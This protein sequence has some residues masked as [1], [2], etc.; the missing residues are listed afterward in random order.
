MR[1]IPLWCAGV[2]LLGCAH[3]AQQPKPNI[4]P[5]RLPSGP[6]PPALPESAAT[7]GPRPVASPD[8]A[9]V[10]GW[11]PLSATRAD[12]FVK[13]HPEWDGRGVLIGILDSGIDAGVPGLQRTPT[14][15]PKILD[16]RDF[17][18][19]GRVPLEKL[20]PVGDSVRIAGTVLAGMSRVRALNTAGPWYGGV[21]V[22]RPLGK[23]PASDINGDGDDA[24]SL[25][26]LVTQA[27]DGWVLLADTDG[28]GSLTGERPIRDYLHGRDTFGWA[29]PQSPSPITIAVN[30]EAKDGVP[31]LDLFFDNGG[32]GTH[33][34]GIAAANDMY[35]LGHFN[36]VAPGAQLLG[37]KISNNAH[38]G[39]TVNGSMVRALDYAI[40]FA[41]AR[42]MPLVLNM[43][44]G[45]G[46]EFEG[47]ARIDLILDSVLAANP[48]VA[49]AISAGNDG[50][51]LSTVGFPGSA[52]RA[53][54]VGATFPL[55]FLA[56]APNDG[57]PDPVAYFSSRGGEI[58]KPDV[59]TPG[60]AYSTVPRWSIGEERKGGTS[61]ASPHAAGILALLASAARAEHLTPPS[62]RELKQAV[63]VTAHPI[64]GA[65]YLDE[66]AGTPDVPAAWQWLTEGHTVPEVG[67]RLEGGQGVS[68]AF[69]R[70]GF[71][72]PGDT[73]Q[74]FIL[75]RPAGSPPLAVT[76]RSDSPWLSTPATAQLVAGSNALEVAYRRQRMSRPGVY[77][78]IVSGWGPDS[79]A[80]PLFR[81]VNTVVVP[82]R[83][84]TTVGPVQLAAGQS[85]RI[86]FAVDSARPFY[87]RVRS[88]STGPTLLG[89]LHQ[90][91]GQPNLDQDVEPAGPGAA[92]AVFAVDAADATNGVWEA[93]ALGSP[94]APGVTSVTI[95]T[96]PVRIGLARNPQGV[97][98]TLDNRTGKAVD[99]QA[100]V[101]LLGAERGV[102][103]PGRGGEEQDV[104]FAVAEWAHDLRIDFEMPAAAWS[105][106]T[107][108]AATVYDPAGHILAEEPLNY[109]R[110]RLTG[111][112]PAGLAGLVA[113]LRLTPAVA[114]TADH[115]GWTMRLR[116][117]QYGTEPVALEPAAGS[118]AQQ[119]RIAPNATAVIKFLMPDSLW[120]MPEAFFPL[121]E[122]IVLDGDL[123]WSRESG[124]PR[125]QGP[126][127][128]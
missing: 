77:V 90:P 124:L 74:R 106:F 13:A 20:Q 32:H 107:D 62:A 100:G 119:V 66:G 122:A 52:A 57:R 50:P 58:A 38:G 6:T 11:M 61:M 78:G 92:A 7:P 56:G 8:A 110:G 109:S 89:A 93:D 2:A 99:L 126:V 46:N 103:L 95:G 60:V 53:L 4:D 85:E 42:Q 73:L 28:N 12:V 69:R 108:F 37:I 3:A 9:M 84:D 47:T 43:S 81:L 49:M 72:G 112:L 5:A 83:P 63:M 54:G 118:D 128:R 88:D 14:G 117:R 36:G 120:A 94:I 79:L 71:A 17:S 29:R 67:V 45:V 22:E 25:P 19:E 111:E 48:D 41:R 96:S 76:L 80:G 31:T 127:M 39:V 115:G 82:F 40:R 113:V 75:E 34:A 59:V 123:R 33:V 105:R 86:F 23:M 114:D 98:L 104:P 102:L 18:G 70:G 91:N 116:I 87:A 16:L 35:G 10:R 101:V 30:L 26:V 55:T 24:D 15:N 27:T 97:D 64:A 68:A 125:P 121:G 44:F 51:G 21:L 65:S 1:R